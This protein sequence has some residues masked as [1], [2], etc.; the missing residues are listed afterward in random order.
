MANTWEDFS[1][2]G[3]S[4]FISHTA[5]SR[6]WRTGGL[7]CKKYPEFFLQATECKTMPG[8]F[9]S[10]PLPSLPSPPLPSF[11]VSRDHQTMTRPKLT[12]RVCGWMDVRVLTLFMCDS[13]VISTA[14]WGGGTAFTLWNVPTVQGK[15]SGYGEEAII[16]SLSFLCFFISR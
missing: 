13:F 7:Q 5:S 4:Y 3:S 12:S 9:P 1:R 11:H 15:E 14:H 10:P 16:F 8:P 6:L 2:E